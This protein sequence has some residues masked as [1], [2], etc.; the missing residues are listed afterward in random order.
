[1][2]ITGV[3]VADGDAWLTQRQIGELFGVARRTV[4]EHVGHVLEDGELRAEAT[5]RNFRRVGQE[6]PRDIARDVSH[7]S[8][9]MVQHIGYRVRSD[10]GVDY[11]RW[12]SSVIRGEVE[13]PATTQP[14]PQPE[15]KPSE[16]V[17]APSRTA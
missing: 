2:S 14:Q 12:V 13:A 10:R 16:L 15:A 1:V 11:R 8:S 9:L 7:Y 5:C 6:G 17:A 3:L 4:G